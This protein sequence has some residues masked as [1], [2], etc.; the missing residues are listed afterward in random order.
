MAPPGLGIIIW[1]CMQYFNY[2]LHLY[3][4]YIAANSA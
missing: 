2:A 1:L 3:D 4:S